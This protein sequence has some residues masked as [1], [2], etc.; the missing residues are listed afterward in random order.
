MTLRTEVLTIIFAALTA[1]STIQATAA[2]PF[3]APRTR[4]VFRT[5]GTVASLTV[6]V[7]QGEA[8]K[9]FNAYRQECRKC[10]NTANLYDVQSELS[11][12]NRNADKAPFKCSPELYKLLQACRK[13]WSVSEGAFDISAKPLMDLWGFYRKHAGS[14]PNDKEIKSVLQKV[15]LEKVVFND[16]EQTVYFTVPGMALD[17]GGIAKGWTVDNMANLLDKNTNAIIDLGGNLRIINPPGK[18]SVIGIRD[19]ITADKIERKI[20]V[21]NA[22]CS[23]SGGYER[24]VV[25]NNRRYAHI[26]DPATG[27]P[28]GKHLAVTVITPSA[29]DSDWMSTAVFIRGK[30]LA[31]K[32]IKLYP[33][34]TVYIY[35]GSAADK[36]VSVEVFCQQ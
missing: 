9:L 16:K 14:M 31:E 17:L 18:S 15:G 27:Y 10:M 21:Q 12:L 24:F 19:P 22:A 34:T 5:M 29:L 7:G 3:S 1:V 23:T 30:S 26:M 13:A 28:A 20:L 11:R 35:S 33:G 36:T 6:N 2:E 8:E 32:I 4:T 25:Y